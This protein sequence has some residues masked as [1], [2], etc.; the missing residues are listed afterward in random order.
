VEVFVAVN[1][2]YMDPPFGL[3][4]AIA[5]TGA[6]G[7]PGIT[8]AETAGPEV[9]RPVVSVP[10]A[11]SQVPESM[12]RL[13]VTAGDTSAMSSDAP[14]PPGGD[15]LTGLGLDFIASTGA[16]QGTVVTPHHPGAARRSS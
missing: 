5:Q 15:P 11:S 2:Q 6:P 16:G 7:S 10:G 14:V 1:D 3:S 13:S 8:A 12:P 4:P 9:G